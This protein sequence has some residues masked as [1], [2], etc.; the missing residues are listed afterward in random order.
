MT[1]FLYIQALIITMAH[2]NMNLAGSGVAEEFLTDE[3]DEEVKNRREKEL[4]YGDHEGG[5]RFTQ[6]GLPLSL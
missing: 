6:N 2:K 1:G 3:R 5:D 4:R